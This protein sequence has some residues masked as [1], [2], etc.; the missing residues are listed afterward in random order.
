MPDDSTGTGEP[1]DYLHPLETFAAPR[2]EDA[3]EPKTIVATAC[4]TCGEQQNAAGYCTNK[5]CSRHGRRNDYLAAAPRREDAAG[6]VQQAVA[7]LLQ[8]VLVWRE[9]SAA[10][11][12]VAADSGSPAPG[13]WDPVGKAAHLANLA[14]ALDFMLAQFR[15]AT[16]A[17][18]TAERER[19]DAAWSAYRRG[20]LD[21]TAYK[22]PEGSL[23]TFETLSAVADAR[24]SQ[25]VKLRARVPSGGER[26]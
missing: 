15:D 26:T 16:A 11:S 8:Q 21:G 5:Q 19:E 20:Y 9:Q 23:D 14:N 25:H 22:P 3:T 2:R 10:A 18:S 17:L 4:N 6:E 13:K 12:R 7:M 24:A 1:M